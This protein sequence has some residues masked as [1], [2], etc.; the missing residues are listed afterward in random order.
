MRVELKLSR[1]AEILDVIELQ[2]S[3]LRRLTEV[4]YLGKTYRVVSQFTTVVKGSPVATVYVRP[5]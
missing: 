5:A 3:N 1:N 4:V 2:P